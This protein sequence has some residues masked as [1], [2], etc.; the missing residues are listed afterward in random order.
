[1]V[2]G[3]LHAWNVSKNLALYVF[4]VWQIAFGCALVLE[5]TKVYGTSSIKQ[6][7][8]VA[9]LAGLSWMLFGILSVVATW[10]DTVLAPFV[11]GA[12][13]IMN[14][15]FS[16]FAGPYR[17]TPASNKETWLVPFNTAIAS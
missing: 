2:T 9:E 17:L 14:G 6:A 7:R 11:I 4:A 15:G 8:R 10:D 3:I 13:A 16:V 5:Q 1:V 12:G